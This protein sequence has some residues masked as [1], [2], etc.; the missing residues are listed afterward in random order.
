MDIVLVLLRLIHIVAAFVWFGV[1]FSQAVVLEPIIAAAG[2]AG[3]RFSMARF[4]NR[5]YKMVFPIAAGVTMLAGIL[6]YIVGNSTSHFSQTGN[7]VLGIGA[8]AGIIA[9]IHGGISTAPAGEAMGA[10]YRQYL[11]DDGISAEGTPVIRERVA[12]L[13]NHT[14]IS[15]VLMVI[16]LVCMGSVRYL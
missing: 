4:E 10:A 13:K 2:T 7:I 14:R 16:A 15:F 1:G 9:V 12:L 8:V 6:L 5:F 3:M 11:T